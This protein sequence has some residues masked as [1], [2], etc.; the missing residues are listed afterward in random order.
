[1]K[2]NRLLKREKRPLFPPAG[3]FFEVKGERENH[4]GVILCMP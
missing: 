4:I 1:M 3:V 2:I